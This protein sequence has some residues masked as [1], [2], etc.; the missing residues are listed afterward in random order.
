[1][2][3]LVETVALAQISP[4]SRIIRVRE[5]PLQHE[6][7]TDDGGEGEERGMPWVLGDVALDAHQLVV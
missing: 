6:V 1:M 4:F 5:N 7:Q 2:Y 3:I